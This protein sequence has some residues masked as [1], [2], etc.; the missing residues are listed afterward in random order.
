MRWLDSIIDSM[1]KYLNK[2]W[3]IVEDTGAW[4]AAVHGDLRV[5][6]D[7]VTEQQVSLAAATSASREWGLLFPDFPNF[8]EKLEI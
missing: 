3:E 5:R 7:L 2:L 6:H 1:D 8:Q 4:Q